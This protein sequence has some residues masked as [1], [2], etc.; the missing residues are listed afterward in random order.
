M[1]DV[2]TTATATS[3]TTHFNHFID[4][5]DSTLHFSNSEKPLIAVEG[6][7]VSSNV[8]MKRLEC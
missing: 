3:P 8:K 5:T 2:G 4:K 7:R 1:K 6:G